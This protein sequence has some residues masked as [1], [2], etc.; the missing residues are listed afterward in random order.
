[1][2][3]FDPS[4]YQAMGFI[5]TF[6]DFS[7][8]GVILDGSFQLYQSVQDNEMKI[9][10]RFDKMTVKSGKNNIFINGIVEMSDSGDM[11]F[12]Q[13]FILIYDGMR[14]IDNALY[15]KEWFSIGV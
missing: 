3:E 10:Y 14:Y 1:M 15:V 9:E 6:D 12:S 13:N 7:E 4:G 11:K 8:S 5:F 2:N